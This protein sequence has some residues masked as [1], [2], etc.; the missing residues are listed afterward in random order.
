MGAGD[1]REAGMVLVVMSVVEQRLDAVR[2]VLAAVPVTQVLA[3]VWASRQ[4]VAG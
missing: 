3:R 2:A 4:S 1:L